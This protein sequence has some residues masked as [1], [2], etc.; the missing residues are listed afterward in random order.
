MS[1]W[2]CRIGGHPLIKGDMDH[3]VLCCHRFEMKT[4]EILLFP[5]M[6]LG[7]DRVLSLCMCFHP[8]GGGGGGG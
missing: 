3:R 1:V 6:G 2:S 5:D 8:W 7:S 4:W